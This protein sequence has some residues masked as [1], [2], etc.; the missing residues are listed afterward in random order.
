MILWLLF[1]YDKYC[2]GQ[3]DA[4]TFE[5]WKLNNGHAK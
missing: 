2:Y 5:Q 3:P 1:I 4:L